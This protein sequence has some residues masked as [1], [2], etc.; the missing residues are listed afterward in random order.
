V[1]R[2]RCNA[3]GVHVADVNNVIRS[4][5]GGQAFSQMTEGEKTFDITLRWP[6]RLRDS[7]EAI[8]TVPVDLNN[9]VV[10]PGLVPAIAPTP[11]TGAITGLS[12]LGTA[13]SM[14]SQFGSPVAGNVSA[15]SNAPRRRL[16]D[17]VVPRDDR[18]F[19]DP[20]GQF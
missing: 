6:E 2:A 15:S 11:L 14:P 10:T 17:L 3:W 9:N 12:A 20:Q 5:V 4:A 18:G 13:A 1:N 16:R 19:P 7:E 8:L